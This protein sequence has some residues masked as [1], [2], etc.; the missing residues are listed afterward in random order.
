[1]EYMIPEFESDMSVEDVCN[2]PD[3]ELSEI[4]DLVIH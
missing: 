1:M 3:D 4:N 2:H